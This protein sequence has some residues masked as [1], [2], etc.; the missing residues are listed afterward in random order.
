MDLAELKRSLDGAIPSRHATQKR[1]STPSLTFADVD[2]LTAAFADV[3]REYITKVTQP[4]ASRIT[5]LEKQQANWR[6]AG[7]YAPGKSYLENNFVTDHSSLWI[8]RRD[9]ASRPGT[10]PDWQ[11]VCKGGGR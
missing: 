10:S 9:T 4:L 2:A 11:L 3:V 1:R 6:F 7:T 5:E 8:C